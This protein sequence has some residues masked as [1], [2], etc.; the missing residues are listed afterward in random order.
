MPYCWKAC[1]LPLCHKRCRFLAHK[2]HYRIKLYPIKFTPPIKIDG[3]NFFCLK[4]WISVVQQK[5]HLKH[6]GKLKIDPRYFFWR[7]FFSQ[8]S[9]LLMLQQPSYQYNKLCCLSLFMD[10]ASTVVG[11]N[12]ILRWT[13]TSNGAYL[14]RIP[15]CCERNPEMKTTLWCRNVQLIVNVYCDCL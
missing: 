2:K 14:P 13:V 5:L 3:Q 8:R 6:K 10:T 11:I 7:D 15:Y 4:F 9:M 12:G 1:T